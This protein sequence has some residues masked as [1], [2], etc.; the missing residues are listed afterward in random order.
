MLIADEALFAKV[1][2]KRECFL[3]PP[4]AHNNE[5]DAIHQTQLPPIRG[6]QRREAHFMM[7]RGYPFHLDGW[8]Y[9]VAKDPDSIH[10]QAA[11]QQRTGF[12]DNIVIRKKPAVP[13]Q[14]LLPSG[15]GC[16]MVLVIGIEKGVE[17]GCIDENH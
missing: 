4:F 13:R 15:A 12:H 6:C 1:R 9:V 11:L 5:A 10:S 14:Q 2:V 3:C 16:G 7:A 17:R 8:Q